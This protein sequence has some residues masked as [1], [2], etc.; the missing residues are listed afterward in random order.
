[1]RHLALMF[2]WLAASGLYGAEPSPIPA[3]AELDTARKEIKEVYEPE[4]SKAATAQQKTELA[5]TLIAKAAA[6]P[7]PARQRYTYVPVKI[8]PASAQATISRSPGF[9]L[10]MAFLALAVGIMIINARKP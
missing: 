8:T 9:D 3:Q 10:L 6:T 2:L 4:F 1:M 7:E 5:T